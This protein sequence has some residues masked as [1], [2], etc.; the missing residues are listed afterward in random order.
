MNARYPM[1]PPFRTSMVLPWR[2]RR[3][4]RQSRPALLPSGKTGPLPQAALAG[5]DDRPRPGLPARLVAD[6][7]DGVSHGLL[8]KGGLSGALRVVQAPREAP[9][10]PPLPR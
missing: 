4:R 3:M 2:A 10:E 6:V 9:Q 7:R 1:D 8:R 5:E